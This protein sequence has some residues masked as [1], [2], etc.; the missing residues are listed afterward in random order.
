[1]RLRALRQN[2]AQLPTKSAGFVRGF[3][4]MREKSE[5]SIK[6]CPALCRGAA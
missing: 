1:M 2:I 6:K 5:G 4:D 3:G